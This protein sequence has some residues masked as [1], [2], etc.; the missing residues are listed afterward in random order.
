M[1]TRR[2]END[3]FCANRTEYDMPGGHVLGVRDD[4][5][6]WFDDTQ[7]TDVAVDGTDSRLLDRM[8]LTTNKLS[9][10]KQYFSDDA[11]EQVRVEQI[12]CC[13]YAFGS[14]LACL[15]IFANYQTNGAYYNP[16]ARVGFSVNLKEHY[17]SLELE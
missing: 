6:V 1:N 4:G 15:R 11:Q 14:E 13:L 2:I 17:F 7:V 12:G 9:Q 10:M 16:K 3:E 8:I 5:Q